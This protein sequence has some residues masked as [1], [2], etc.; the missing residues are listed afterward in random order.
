MMAIGVKITLKPND[1]QRG[2]VKRRRMMTSGQ[3]RPNLFQ[4]R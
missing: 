1:D 4:G 2:I 3:Q